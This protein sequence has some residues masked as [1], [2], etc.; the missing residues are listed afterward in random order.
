MAEPKIA[1]IV[2]SYSVF[3]YARRTLLS[4]AKYTPNVV[5]IVVDDASPDWDGRW[6]RDVNV[7]VDV[8]RFEHNGGL[9]RSWNR[10]FQMARKHDPDFIVAGNNDVLFTMGWYQA[11]I[12]AINSGLALVGPLSNAP[13]ETAANRQNIK[14]YVLNYNLTDVAK[15]NN[16][17]AA[18]LWKEYRSKV[19]STKING[20]FM[21]A[22]ADTWFDH[23]YDA[24]NV[25]C[26]VN[27]HMPS[28][29]QNT[30]PLMTGNEDELQARW[31]KRGLRFGAAP[32]SF[33][34]HYRS[35]SRGSKY[36]KGAWMRMTDAE[37]EV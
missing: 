19:I 29:R 14:T 36:V 21:M 9:T 15:Y 27:T 23:A 24:R 22:R 35:V 28:G 8:H 4:L 1:V 13:G 37:K 18:M 34:F 3:D 6:Y 25:F 31:G 32:G 7:E 5:A 26:P 17:L 11:L 2:P 33:I 10:G 30:T 20:F 12:G 16:Q